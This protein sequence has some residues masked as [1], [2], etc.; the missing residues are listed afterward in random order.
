[1]SHGREKMATLFLVSI[2]LFASSGTPLVAA[3]LTYPACRD[4]FT[5]APVTPA[6][7]GMTFDCAYIGATASP[8]RGQVYH[9]H[10]NDGKRAKAMFFDTM[11]QLAALGYASV[12]CDARGYSP[13]ASP[14]DY[15]AYHYDKLAADIID[16]VDAMGFGEKFDGKFHLVTHDQ[17]ARVA[18]HSIA[19]NITRPRLLSFTSLSIPHSDVFSDALLSA[20]PDAN[21]QLA[22]Q[23]VRM[24]VLP[25]ST[26]VQN[27]TIF[28]KVCEPEGW[29]ETWA[30]QPSLWWYNGA[31][32]SGAMALTKW[33]PNAA[34]SPVSKYVGIDFKTVEKLTQYPLE[35]V[36]QSVRVGRV[37]EFPVLYA[38]GS[39]DTSDLCES[40]FDTESRALIGK[41]TYL[42]VVGCGHD[43]LGCKQAQ[44]YIDAIIKN[45][46]Q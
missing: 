31:I 32:D 25:N 3:S 45:I 4:G 35:G 27:K 12:A 38:C 7:S 23:Y 37:D 15:G 28:H 5:C 29:S 26:L 13:G 22:A 20:H 18:W 16:I 9:M 8:T 46:Q 19:K 33:D 30:C 2:V 43:V 34:I 14:F 10:G 41:Y 17:G 36:A 44:T 6:G 24:L 11:L 1:M 40:A 39:L 42:K 21:Q